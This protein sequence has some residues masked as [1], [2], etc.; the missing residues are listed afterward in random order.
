MTL[1]LGDPAVPQ[2]HGGPDRRWNTLWLFAEDSWRLHH[3]VTVTYGLAW[4][5]DGVLNHD[6]RKPPLLAPL[7]GASGLGPT[8]RAWTNFSPALGAVWT[9]SSDRKTVVRAG[10]GRYYRPH[11]L[12]SSLDAERAMLGPPGLGRQTFVGS[13]IFNP[14]PGI[15]GV[16]VGTPLDFGNTPTQLTGAHAI[17]A[18]PAITR[19][20]TGRLASA[21][22]SFQQIEISKQ[23]ARAIFPEGVPNPSA[24]HLSTG[25]QAEILPG[26]VVSA[27]L[28]WRRFFDAPQNGGAI[29]LNRFDSAR[30]PVIPKCS[31]EDATNPRALCSTGPFNVYLSPYR[32]LNRALVARVDKRSSNGWQALVSYAFARNSG[33]IAGNGFNLENWDENTGP[34][35][36]AHTLNVAGGARLPRQFDLAFNFSYASASPFSVFVGGID[37]NGDGTRDD[38]L[39]GT[40]ANAFNRTM[41]RGDLRRLVDDFNERYAGTRVNGTLAPR[42]TLPSQFSFGDNFHALDLRLSRTMLTRDNLRVVIVAEA[43]NVYNAAN[44]AGHSGD[45][46]NTSAFGQPTLRATQ[47]FGSGGPRA[48]QLAA[49]VSF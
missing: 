7:L 28:V 33:T 30:G 2:E 1:S 21:D 29:D 32:F 22:R 14:V 18:L 34:I 12:T 8:R 40:S 49:R 48:F 41:D 10:T 36:P 43:F 19:D 25:V 23:A 27:D 42:L 26:W 5:Y 15:A 39:P 4:S 46:A 47:V 31:V 11:G 6:L 9:L 44:L 3:R 16:P 35:G 20:L 38:L 37:F 17:A 24:I 45:V 13:S